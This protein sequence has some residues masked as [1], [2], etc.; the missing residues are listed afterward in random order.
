MPPADSHRPFGTLLTAMVTPMTDDGA[1]DLDAAAALAVHL[2]DHG[3]DGLVVN[4]TTGEA[5]T[6]TDDEKADLVRVVADAVGGRAAV[7]AGAGSNDTRHA[8]ATA[9]RAADAGATGLLAVTPYYSRPSQDGVVA[10]LTAVA[11]ATDLPVLLYDVPARTGVRLTP[12]SYHRLAA[13]PRVVAVK[14][15]TGDV[16]AATRL[17]A[18]T[19]RRG[20][21][22]PGRTGR[23]GPQLV[24]SLVVKLAHA[25]VSSTPT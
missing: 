4:G 2:V 16:P 11:D 20:R 9:R 18:D 17:V 23:R 21:R 24:T 19:G 6:T 14:D 3:H 10:H 7:V 22:G 13:H 8:V 5:P 15:A 1:V 12:S 25:A